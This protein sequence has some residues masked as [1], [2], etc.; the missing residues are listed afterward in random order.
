MVLALAVVPSST[1]VACD[2]TSTVSVIAPTC[3]AILILKLSLTFSTMPVRVSVLN[4]LASTLIEKF[5]IGSS[6]AE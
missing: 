3:N 1:A 6:G 4:P 2:F 5:P